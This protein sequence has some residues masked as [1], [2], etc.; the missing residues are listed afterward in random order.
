MM[1]QKE[2]SIKN[3]KARIEANTLEMKNKYLNEKK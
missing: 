3:V 2:D 1:K